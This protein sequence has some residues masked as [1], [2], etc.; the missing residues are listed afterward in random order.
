MPL[1]D[2][3]D[4]MFLYNQKIDCTTSK[5]TLNASNTFT[6]IKMDYTGASMFNN[7]GTNNGTTTGNTSGTKVIYNVLELFN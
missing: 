2:K 1:G 4:V 3:L 7:K 5:L 6:N